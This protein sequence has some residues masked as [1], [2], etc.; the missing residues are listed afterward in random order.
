MAAVL[1][2]FSPNFTNYLGLPKVE[3]VF[4]EQMIPFFTASTGITESI[5]ITM[6]HDGFAAKATLST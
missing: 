6:T 4:Q 3:K 2:K 5:T 1:K